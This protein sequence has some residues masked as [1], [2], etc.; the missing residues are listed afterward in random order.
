MLTFPL[1]GDASVVVIE[2][3]N[4]KRLKAG[5]PLKVGKHLLCF[6]PDLQAF[7]EAAIGE[8]MAAPE[9]GQTVTK[10]IRLSPEQLEQALRKCQQL[11]EVER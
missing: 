9:P 5:K 10:G 3:G 1:D 2:P 4:I 11:P 7:I 8:D 6:T